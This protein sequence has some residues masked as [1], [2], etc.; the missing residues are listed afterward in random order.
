MPKSPGERSLVDRYVE[1]VREGTGDRYAV[2]LAELATLLD[3]THRSNVHRLGILT[4]LQ[5]AIPS[6][7]SRKHGSTSEDSTLEDLKGVLTGLI[8]MQTRVND[9]ESG[10]ADLLQ[11]AGAL[12]AASP[13]EVDVRH[14]AQLAESIVSAY[15]RLRDASTSARKD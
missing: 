4:A 1:A 7:E 5:R 12:N 6:P 9:R 15:L 10:L 2:A 8:I 13:V 3:V 11:R 14:V